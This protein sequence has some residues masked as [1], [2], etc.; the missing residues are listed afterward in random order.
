MGSVSLRPNAR[1]RTAAAYDEIVIV[2]GAGIIG[3]SSA[4]RMARAGVRVLVFDA[5]EAAAEASWAGAGM[6]APGGEI[7]T[8]SELAAMALR[9]LRAYDVFVRELGNETGFDIDFQRCGALELAANDAESAVLQRKADMQQSMGIPSE[10]RRWGDL[11]AR[12][13]PEDAMVD[14][15][16]V[17]AA[18]RTAC[19]RLGVVLR[20]HEP[21]L[22]IAPEGAWVRT[23]RETI[24]DPDGVLIAAGAWSSSLC[25]ALP[26]TI[27][28]RGHLV[29]WN[30]PPGTLPSIVRHDH[31][32][33]L[34]RRNGTLI[35]G[36]S[37]EDAGFDRTIDHA[38]VA[39]I[40]DRA[41]RLL[42]AL[43]NMEPS[44]CWIGFRPAIAGAKGVACTPLVGQ[45]GPRLWAAVGHYRNGILLAPET[46][47]V[48]TE[49][50]VESLAG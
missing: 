2:T 14:P 29:S 16:Q 43:A 17:T 15:R 45:I 7:D 28:V 48:I 40:R 18:L 46:A 38:I 23:G 30:L 25:P 12:F 50:V 13:Y 4:W 37:T 36:S 44:A 5:R 24:R 11:E 20:E 32:Y 35:A 27:P 31:T 34:Q 22:E 47:R 33:L 10:S 21:A 3:L 41:V 9:S 19:L 39:D 49:S 1:Q 26:R 8:Q 42:P 6:L